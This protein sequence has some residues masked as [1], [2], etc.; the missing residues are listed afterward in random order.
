MWIFGRSKKNAAG[1]EGEE[2][3]K[4]A[5]PSAA[6]ARGG[7][8]SADS[9]ATGPAD[10]PAS[11]SSPAAEADAAPSTLAERH[12]AQ[13]ERE[14]QAGASAV[15]AAEI[16]DTGTSS[17]DD[18]QHF[19]G[20]VPRLE[21]LLPVQ[22]DEVTREDRVERALDRWRLTMSDLADGRGFLL[23]LRGGPEYLDLTNSHPQGLAHLF[24]ARGATRLSSLV[25]EPGSLATA[26]R[27]ARALREIA[28]SFAEERG[29]TTCYL[30]IGEA[31]WLP[32]D[33]GSVIHAPIMLRPINLFLRGNAREDIDLDLDAAV[34]LNPV[35]LKAMREAGVILD[36]RSLLDLTASI[37]GFDP[38]PVIDAFRSLGEPLLNFRVSHALV[39]GSLIDSS[40]SMLED[41]DTP[42]EDLADNDLIA[43]L[44]GDPEAREALSPE[45][46][47]RAGTG[48]KEADASS[49][50]IAIVDPDEAR[51]LSAIEDTDCLVVETA[52]GAPATSTIVNLM[53]EL[54]AQ[55]KRVLVVSQRSSHLADLAEAVTAAGIGDLLL[56]LSPDPQLQRTTV[57][58][59]LV[60]LAKANSFVPPVSMEED[61]ALVEAAESLR[62]H[63]TAMHRRQEPW[64]ASAHDAINAL[65]GLLRRD[66]APRTQVRLPAD[67]AR[68]VGER[69]DEYRELLERA[70]A[71]R[72]LYLGADV[73][74][75]AGAHITTRTQA[76]RAL[77][78]AEALDDEHL[79]ELIRRSRE[80][81]KQAH[82]EPAESID[83]L[84]TQIRVLERVRTVTTRFDAQVFLSDLDA[85]IAA[86]GDKKFRQAHGIKQGM[87]QRRALRQEAAGYAKDSATPQEL[88]E[89]LTGV[90]GVA[91]DWRTHSTAPDS[92]PVVPADL[93]DLTAVVDRCERS[94]DELEVLLAGTRAGTEFGRR[95]IT[96]I[97]EQIRELVEDKQALEDLPE[98]TTILRELDFEGL[99]R[100][101]ADLRA[102]ELEE[103][104]VAAELDLA[105]WSSVFEF[106][107]AK[108]PL[109]SEHTGTDLSQ[110]AERYRRLDAQFLAAQQ[111]RV[112]EQADRILVETMKRY[113]DTS[114]AAIVELNNPGTTSVKDVVAKYEQIMFRAR[115]LWLVSPYMVPQL[116]PSGV[117]FD[118]V[119][120]A[121]GARLPTAAAVPALTR[122]DRAVVIGDAYE[123]AG[124]PPLQ[125]EAEELEPGALPMANNLLLD[126]LRAL[127]PIVRIRRDQHPATG[128]VRRFVSRVTRAGR[129][130]ELDAH[131]LAVP[132]PL[133]P[134][135]DLFIHVE[136]G[137]GPVAADTAYVE[138]TEAEL[139]RI[140]DL[141]V[142]H[143]RMSPERSLAVVTVT[144]EHAK[145]V[146]DR[147]MSTVSRMPELRDFFQPNV[148]EAFVVTPA[149]GATAVERDDIIVSLGFGL[150]PHGRLF[151]SFGP[152]S[153]PH[154]RKV[155]VSLLTRSRLRTVVVSSLASADFDPD[156]LTTEGARD[157]Y[158]LLR[159]LEAGFD[160]A[161]LGEDDGTPDPAEQA[162]AAPEPTEQAAGEQ[163]ADGASEY[164]EQEADEQQAD[165]APDPAEQEATECAED[166][167]E[168]ADAS[169]PVGHSAADVAPLP[170]PT[171]EVSEDDATA[172]ATPAIRFAEGGDSHIDALVADLADR[173][174]ER[175]LHT[176]LD[177]GLSHDRIELAV[178]HRDLPGRLLVAVET[179][180]ARYATTAD[181]R[182]RDRLRTERLEAA[183]W[184]V[185]RVWSWALFIDPE[186]E[187][188]RVTRTVERAHAFWMERL[189]EPVARAGTT[190]HRLPRPKVPAGHP[191]SF[192]GAEDFDAVVAYIS[193]D[194]RARLTEQLAAE[195]RE[196][197]GFEQR[198]LLLDVSVSSAIRRYQESHD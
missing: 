181:Q 41:F 85:L 138:S 53:A 29:L 108:E 145:R 176:E 109:L 88:H 171:L 133:P 165:G 178:G 46:E 67:V 139:R 193:S 12:A 136:D 23:D 170:E 117:H 131:Q 161:V 70:A 60:S 34:E 191:L 188:D 150:T 187:A 13:R 4:A 96:D 3:T 10:A 102:R 182:E 143:A 9:A 6:S 66:P 61:P 132:S 169:E 51:A 110:I 78:L 185:E 39:V 144:A 190:R 166:A 125:P 63:L 58:S 103:E 196:F 174:Q 177:Y 100:L 135:D 111:Y 28:Q 130:D 142:Q 113:R 82:L 120:V 147:I 17:V 184:V 52:P 107:A 172:D 152:L 57:E 20:D 154:G 106:I 59:L 157:L 128:G 192:Y 50:P 164:A 26:R 119:I 194:G 112:R 124:E 155:L 86:T 37:H 30:G 179:D 148:P 126:D 160:A 68:R 137:R 98:Q 76:D 153:G 69:P 64:G 77:E 122:A 105:W 56:D 43:A 134:D 14:R 47:K 129:P 168:S 183:G 8:G 159:F 101:V 19:T 16:A 95:P 121:D 127:A 141:V 2:P 55:Q 89:A 173:L 49:A 79:P 99:G 1:A 140:T 32:S 65:S 71:T 33:G 35:L 22:V 44:A 73:T 180:G 186:G 72:A 27:H 104:N 162:A 149:I 84:R 118:V 36:A 151:H 24:A 83:A 40:V 38:S 48:D 115:P 74:P 116:I 114:R 62:E 7:T 81:T 198:S 45:G 21:G 158:D 94:L 97:Q 87:R 25:R 15:P 92:Q 197:L 31:S 11:A 189:Q 123:Y 195:V 175:G 167:G 91:H 42:S 93:D 146:M 18:I 75:W 54:A 5:E 163:Q 156:R 80:M 90:R